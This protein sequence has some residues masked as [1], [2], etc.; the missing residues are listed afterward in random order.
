MANMA[1]PWFFLRVLCSVFKASNVVNP[2]SSLGPL[3]VWFMI[4][5]NN[6]FREMGHGL[7]LNTSL[8]PRFPKPS[9]V[10]VRLS[11]TSLV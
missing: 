6:E 1:E 5:S 11:Q 4:P 9:N 2:K 8:N 3:G 7:F 10:P